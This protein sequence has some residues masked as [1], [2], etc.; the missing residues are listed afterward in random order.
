[1]RERLV[2][3][4]LGAGAVVAWCG[5]VSGFHRDSTAA[6]V[7][8]LCSLA[9]VIVIDLLLWRGRRGAR[10][11]WHLAPVVDPWPRPGRG[12]AGRALC[13][14]APWL[15]VILIALTWDVLGLDSGPHSYH[16]TISA[17]SQAY[18]P[19]NA[20]VLLAWLACGVGYEVA[21]ARA[22]G[23]GA[24]PPR[25][26][27]HDPGD[28]RANAAFGVLVVAPASHAHSGPALLLP[29]SPPLGVAFWLAVP[30]AAVCLDLVA[31]H[32]SGKV[33][34]AEEFVRF[35]STSPLANLALI[36]A[37]VF[38]GYHLFAR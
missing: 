2:A 24:Q 14:V 15:V 19:L 17:L 32:S 34:N 12:G 22:P 16:L 4:V 3:V 30:A 10:P 31:R 7:T 25:H 33:A 8:W 9:A 28:A 23:P 21:R 6:V 37:W 5:W 35:V 11:G 13:G 36:A 20:A 27:H 1:V 18:R 29:S 26:P 38:A